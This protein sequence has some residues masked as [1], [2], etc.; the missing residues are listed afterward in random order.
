MATASGVTWTENASSVSFVTKS[1]HWTRASTMNVARSPVDGTR[2]L[3]RI[4]RIETT[5]TSESASATS[6]ESALS[7][8]I[9]GNEAWL[10]CDWACQPIEGPYRRA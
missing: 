7:E 8:K 3:P 9:R 6:S 1:E 2:R 10:P 4:N 5:A